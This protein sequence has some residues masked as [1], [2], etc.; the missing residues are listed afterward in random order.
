MS[1]IKLNT[2]VLTQVA[3]HFGVDI[4]DVEKTDKGELKRQP[5]IKAITNSGI[6][7]EMYKQAFP[8]IEDLPE[9]EK[10]VATNEK[11]EEKSPVR[12]EPKVLLR[13][14][15]SNPLFEVRGYKFS[16]DHPFNAV[17]QSDAEYIIANYEGFR[18]ALPS[19]AEEFYS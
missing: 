5:L 11:T 1:F 10:P 18:V 7:W 13:M 2:D 16:K 19:E 4:D 3:D 15:R 9:V 17:A 12:E 6:T 8:D 14:L